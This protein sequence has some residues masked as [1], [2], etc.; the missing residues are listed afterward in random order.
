MARSLPSRPVRPAR[1][2][3]LVS[4][5]L[6][7]LA[8]AGTVATTVAT[9][10]TAT[11]APRTTSPTAQ[12]PA[13]DGRP[14]A[15]VPGPLRGHAATQAALNEI[16]R[17]GTPG[18]LARA[19]V[20]GSVW[21][22]TSGVADVRT[23]RPRLPADRFRTG[24]LTKP[25]TATVVL[26][27]AGDP[28][29]GL[30]LDDSIEKWLPGVV[31]GNDNDGNRVTLRH[32]LQHTSGLYDY[33]RDDAFRSKYT[34]AAFFDH[35]FDGATAE[36]LVAVGLA[37]RPNFAPGAGWSYSNTNYALLGM[38]IEK[39]TGNSYATETQRRI[40]KPL[41]L[42]GTSLPGT[43]P[44]LPGPHGRHYS[45]LFIKDP[46]APRYDVT[47]LNPSIASSG[48][49]II[50]TARDLNVFLRALVRGELLRPAQQREMFTGRD[51]GDGESYGLGIRSRKLK[52][53]DVTLWGHAGDI[54]GSLSHTLA[55]P[56]GDH[57][58]T[59]NRNSDWGD[60]EQEDAAIE[61]EFCGPRA[62]AARR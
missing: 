28:R 23:S 51:L 42:T 22:G 46:A 52:T 7:G 37:H 60:D 38:V 56:D 43:A 50:S 33:L 16:V 36:E 34:G 48:G 55:T 4:R 29:Y 49:E 21:Y 25:F 61:A 20:K 35:R 62:P 32:L 54:F 2:G 30:S 6:L 41:G 31:Q 44:G 8:L 40:I 24:S 59:L 11:A 9:T 47:E 53:C 45:K 13:A 26:Q 14:A 1:T 18:A 3:R 39:A 12:A 5:T 10:G 15:T 17:T 27:L 19:D 57:V 58:L